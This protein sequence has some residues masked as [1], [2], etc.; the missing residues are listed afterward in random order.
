MAV[1]S[2]SQRELPLTQIIVGRQILVT[3]AATVSL[4]Q[5][6]ENSL[7]F[8]T[9]DDAAATGTLRAVITAGTGFVVTSLVGAGDTGYFAY[10]VVIIP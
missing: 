4:K 9:G 7:I 1:A 8:L 10:L 5:I 3:G 2:V 6:T